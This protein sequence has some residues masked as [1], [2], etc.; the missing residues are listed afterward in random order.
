MEDQLDKMLALMLQALLRLPV[1]SQLSVF[2]PHAFARDG[3][4]F[5]INGDQEASTP[6]AS[7]LLSTK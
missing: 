5:A 4:S 2:A 6:L 3:G 7:V 1:K